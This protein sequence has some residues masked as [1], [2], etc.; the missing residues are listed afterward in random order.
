[1]AEERQKYPKNFVGAV[2]KEYPR[3]LALHRALDSG[4]ELLG[5]YLDD[6][7]FINI[8]PEEIVKTISLGKEKVLL[9]KAKKIIHRRNLY[10]KWLH[11]CQKM[12]R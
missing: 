8:S 9:E 7:G 2:K 3:Y 12:F 5:R 6:N 10:K 1:M 4:A 11:V